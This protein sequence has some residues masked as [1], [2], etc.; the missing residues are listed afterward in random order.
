[1]IFAK[2]KKKRT[3]NDL[4]RSHV[5]V[6]MRCERWICNE[7]LHKLV[8]NS[9]VKAWGS[10]NPSRKRSQSSCK[11]PSVSLIPIQKNSFNF[12]MIWNK[13]GGLRAAPGEDLWAIYLP[14]RSSWLRKWDQLFS[15]RFIGY[16]KCQLKL[17]YCTGRN[18][19]GACSLYSTHVLQRT[20]KWKFLIVI[21]RSR[22]I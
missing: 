15:A 16:T 17:F 11:N 1:M 19:K 3:I 18:K 21:G 22:W 13:M 7:M 10:S 2:S 20:Q 4:G 9:R 6:Y 5:C 14:S 8:A 12:H